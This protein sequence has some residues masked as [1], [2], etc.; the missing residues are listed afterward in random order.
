MD[1]LS[2]YNQGVIEGLS[3]LDLPQNIKLAAA[4]YL[5][6]KVAKEGSP[7]LSGLNK[8]VSDNRARLDQDSM[9]AKEE[10]FK[11]RT[12][13]S[14]SE[15]SSRM[16]RLFHPS[17]DTEESIARQFLATSYPED[18]D[19]EL[20]VPGYKLYP[21]EYNS[22]YV[23]MTERQLRDR[24]EKEDLDTPYGA[25]VSLAEARGSADVIKA[26]EG[27]KAESGPESGLAQSPSYL[28]TALRLAK[29]N[30]G[31]AAAAGLGTAGLGYGAY[32][33]LS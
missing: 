2:A 11:E 28:Q 4:R 23:E 24:Q 5:L 3:T 15:A 6:E 29:E 33:A 30:P 9:E 18:Y 14:P 12:G 7:L 31:M 25:P 17:L 13:I 22:N 19:P 8:R 21:E 27:L 10:Y 16:Y 20:D 26:L 1:K 32:K